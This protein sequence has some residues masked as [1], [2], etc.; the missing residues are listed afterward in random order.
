MHDVASGEEW[1]MVVG[2]VGDEEKKIKAMNSII[3]LFIF[4]IPFVRSLFAI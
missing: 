2:P 3:Q 1:E 4:C